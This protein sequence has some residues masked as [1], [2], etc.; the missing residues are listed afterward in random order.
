MKVPMSLL[1]ILLILTLNTYSNVNSN[2]AHPEANIR[3]PKI[4]QLKSI[5]EA[6]VLDGKNDVR[7]ITVSGLTS[8]G[9]WID[10]SKE[11]S[12]TTNDNKVKID[13]NGHVH[14]LAVGWT[15]IKIAF[16]HHS[17]D[18]SVNVEN[19]DTQPISIVRDVRSR[20]RLPN[21]NHRFIRPPS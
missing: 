9:H 19:V 11:A 6:L 16:R 7:S 13:N 20:S 21:T 2:S 3:I 15:S 8:D 18:L 14:P 12:F 1:G 10:L 17:I 5:P 4:T